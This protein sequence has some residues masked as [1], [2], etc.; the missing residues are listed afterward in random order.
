[1]ALLELFREAKARDGAKTA[2]N[3]GTSRADV[4]AAEH[5]G[6]GIVVLSLQLSLH[7]SGLAAAAAAVSNVDVDTRTAVA[8]RPGMGPV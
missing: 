2:Y 5:G 8:L 4:E 6:R 3:K 1:M 7:R